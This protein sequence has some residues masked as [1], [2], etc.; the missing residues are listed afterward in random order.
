M[1]FWN[2]LRCFLGFHDE[3][4]IGNV[5]VNDALTRRNE[6][7]VLRCDRDNCWHTRFL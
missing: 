7:A 2:W 5:T 4:L 1:R 3:R 6:F